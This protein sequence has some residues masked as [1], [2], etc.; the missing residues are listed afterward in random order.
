MTREQLIDA[1]FGPNWLDR[2]FTA[3]DAAICEQRIDE[4]VGLLAP[5]S[6]RLK[7]CQQDVGNRVVLILERRITEEDLK[8]IKELKL[9]VRDKP[10]TKKATADYVNL[11]RQVDAGCRKYRAAGGRLSIPQGYIDLGIMIGEAMLARGVTPPPR[12]DRFAV[13][14]AYELLENWGYE[15]TVSRLSLWH[16]VATALLAVDNKSVDLRRQLGTFLMMKNDAK[17]DPIELAFWTFPSA[18]MARKRQK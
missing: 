16:K 14:A 9:T 10:P 17:I 7:Q 1:V 5:P 6:E 8:I 15:P 13:Q 4:I 11:L 3:E 12:R 18:K 2:G